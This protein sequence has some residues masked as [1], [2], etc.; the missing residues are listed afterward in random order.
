MN[1]I[2]FYNTKST[3][4]IER[5]DNAKMSSLHQL[6]L[7]Y[8]PPKGKVLDI[9]FGSGRDLQFLYDHGYDIWG[10]DP[11]KKFVENAKIR[12]SKNRDHFFEEGIPFQKK[13]LE[14]MFQFDAII[15]IAVW[16]HLRQD[17]YAEAVENIT[18]VSKP[19]GVVVISY[20]K[21]KRE[22]EDERYFEDVNL[23]NL[24]KLFLAKDFKLIE[25][26]ENEDS[27]KRNS[28]SWVTVVFKHD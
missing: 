11:A 18:S 5:Y 10:T 9:G 24:I 21:G 20:S 1:T 8:I 25:T 17:Q 16:M 12:F 26:V 27:L 22:D 7:K 28:L 23:K 13:E 2:D 4:L 15:S 14:E 6:L 3:Q 19:S